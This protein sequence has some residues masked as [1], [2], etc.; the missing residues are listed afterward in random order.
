MTVTAKEPLRVGAIG[1]DERQRNALKMIFDGACRK[2]YCFADNHPPEAFI[3]DLDQ[4]GVVDALKAQW[5]MHGGRPMLFLSVN[6]PAEILIDGEKI[7]GSYLKKPFRIDDFV[8]LLPAL[9]K[10]ARTPAAKSSSP[11]ASGQRDHRIE[12]G[13]MGETVKT[14]HVAEMLNDDTMLSLAGSAE[15]I[16][17]SDPAQHEQIYYSPDRFLQGRF[18]AAWQRAKAAGRP[19]AVEGAWPR[20]V[21]FPT[22]N[23]I[24]LSAPLRQYRPFAIVPELKGDQR[25]TL[26]DPSI[27]ANGDCMSYDAFLWILTLWAA[28]G[29]LPYGT[30]LDQPIFLKWWPN[31]TRLDVSPS[32]LAISALWTREPHSLAMTVDML[33]IP[34]RWVFAFYSAAHAIGL[35]GVSQRAVDHMAIPNPPIPK[36]ERRGFLGRVQG[37]LRMSK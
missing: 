29:R 11:D 4:V 22:E 24:Q 28:R 25:E 21:F 8:A 31:F 18:A 23:I 3:V 17:L 36:V 34:Q 1:F 19:M 30:P 27:K 16:D 7:S 32:A 2:S 15:D 14:S 10:T 37:K 26:F 9:A 13:R 20:V 5:R 33:A 35:T 12:A 6:A